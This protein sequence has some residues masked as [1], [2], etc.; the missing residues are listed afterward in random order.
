MLSP[1]AG[2]MDLS[3]TQQQQQQ[4]Q[5]DGPQSSVMFACD[6]SKEQ[7]VDVMTECVLG[8]REGGGG[9]C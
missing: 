6:G 7:D 8:G 9:I 2:G 4:Q 3:V 5:Q 1:T